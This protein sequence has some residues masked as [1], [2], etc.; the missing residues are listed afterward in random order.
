MC[1]YNLMTNNSGVPRYVFLLVTERERKKFFPPRLL[2]QTFF[3]WKNQ[4]IVGA[5]FSQS[6][7]TVTK[8]GKRR[9][10]KK[11][12]FI[13]VFILFF[14]LIH[15]RKH[16]K[17]RKLDFYPTW[18][19]LSITLVLYFPNYNGC[20]IVQKYAFYWAPSHSILSPLH[21][22]CLVFQIF[23]KKCFYPFHSAQ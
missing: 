13:L 22:N 23:Q 18:E 5:L 21:S 14:R 2:S 9:G 7:S 3:W 17:W 19:V 4:I 12:R 6:C 11:I 8:G 15:P 16:T 20:N 10:E 1:L